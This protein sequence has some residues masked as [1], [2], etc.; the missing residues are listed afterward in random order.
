MS[1]ETNQ[2]TTLKRQVSERLTKYLVDAG[3]VKQHVNPGHGLQLINGMKELWASKEFSDILIKTDNG[4]TEAHKNILAS[5]SPYFKAMFG[6]NMKESGQSTIV[7]IGVDHGS[8][9]AVLGF[10][11]T[12]EIEITGVT[13]AELLAV[14]NFIGT[15]SLVEACGE[16]LVE[17]MKPE[18]SLDILLLADSQGLKDLFDAVKQYVLLKF[19]DVVKDD[20][21]LQLPVA[22]VSDLLSDELLCVEKSGFIPSPHDQ[23][24][25]IWDTVLRYVNHDLKE[26]DEHLPSLLEYVRLSLLQPSFLLDVISTNSLIKNSP[27]VIEKIRTVLEKNEMQ[28]SAKE[29][30]TVSISPRK[31]GGKFLFVLYQS[32]CNDVILIQNIN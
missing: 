28:E 17:H 27:E 15:E 1:S 30:E 13:V 14:S 4:E 19:T 2:P 26:R 9:E 23:E 24:L 18:N 25:F 12:G 5:F 16:F 22:L 3:N 7:M 11:Y 31:F 8:L 6:P 20:L 10:I 32:I 21:F 29:K